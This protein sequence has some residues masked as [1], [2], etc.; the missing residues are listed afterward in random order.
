M[1]KI[2]D[3]VKIAREIEARLKFP[4]ITP[5]LAVLVFK[6]DAAGRLY[7]R[8]KAEAAR[9]L[10]IKFIQS[11]DEAVIDRWNRDDSIHGILIQRPAYRGEEFEAHWQELVNRIVPQKDVDGL[12]P[13]SKFVP[14]TVK[15]VEEIL[16]S[17]NTPPWRGILIVG[18]GMVGRALAKRLNA[19]NIS[20][21][22][23]NLEA[24]SRKAE[25]LISACGRENLIKTVKPGAVVIDAGWPKGDV[26]FDTVKAD[27][28]AITPVPGG[29]GPVTVACLL[30]N[31]LL[32]V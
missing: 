26:D 11:E 32:T 13:D 14:A 5:C 29:V 2:I 8:L 12:R 7:A 23:K 1:A 18:R 28:R 21:K 27:A 10:G 15:A 9:H 20:S 17:V 22:D 4:G 31:L 16:A 3:G 19:K 25:I 30:E 24:K 6:D